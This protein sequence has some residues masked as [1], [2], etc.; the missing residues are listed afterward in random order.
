MKAAVQHRPR[1]AGSAEAIV[2][3]R[4]VTVTYRNGTSAIEA[5]K[6]VSVDIRPGELLLVTGPSGSGK[7]SILQV[8]GLLLEPTSGEV[9]IEGERLAGFAQ[10]RLSALRRRYCGFVFQTYNLFPTLTAIEN[11][12]TASDLKGARGADAY[13][14]AARLLSRVD[15]ADKIDSYPATL[16]GGQKQRVAVARALAGDP[17]LILADEPTAAL[18]WAAGQSTM[19]LLRSLADEE[20]RAIVVVT[21]DS[22][23]IS[24]ADRI[25]AM[26]DGRLV[27]PETHRSL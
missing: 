9:I 24:F 5:V 23:I 20:K 15:L 22:R 17:P 6:D 3:L 14:R 8:L 16:S 4:D 2:E 13:R 21:H 11:V 25:L 7:T 27:T 10:H 12:M 18:D 26:Q 1:N 19:Q